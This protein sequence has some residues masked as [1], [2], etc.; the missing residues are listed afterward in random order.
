MKTKDFFL[1]IVIALALSGCKKEDGPVVTHSGLTRIDYNITNQSVEPHIYFE[2]NNTYNLTDYTNCMVSMI[3]NESAPDLN[4]AIMLED[5]E[6]NRSD[7]RVFEISDEQLIKD[8]LSHSYSFDFTNRP[9]SSSAAGKVNIK[10]VKR[11]YIY[12]TSEAPSGGFFWLDKVSFDE[13]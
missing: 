11:I 8:D 9:G 4:L 3:V 12:I 5:A 10:A 6:G 2:F 1:I 7:N 13:P